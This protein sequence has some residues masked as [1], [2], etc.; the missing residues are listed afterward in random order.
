MAYE[1]V[2]VKICGITNAEDALRAGS[3]GADLAGFIFIKNT[4][5]YIGDKKDIILN[6]PE[7]L[8]KTMLKVGLFQDE[9]AKK[10]AESVIYCG[11]DYVQLQG[12]ESPEYCAFLKNILQ[13]AKYPCLIKIIKAF[14]I[15][16][17]IFSVSGIYDVLSYRD[18]VDYF[19]FDTFHPVLAGGTGV[20]FNADILIKEKESIK[21]PF[22]IAGGLTPDNAAE[23]IKRFNP[24]GVDV[25]SG[26][27]KILG[28]KDE[29]LLKEFI[30]N[31]KNA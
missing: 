15:K 17:R 27:E 9:D 29:S 10:V 25:S 18:I 28:K 19:V 23:I 14:K 31:A 16:D 4:P 30:A 1:K 24:Y 20:T 13:Q 11:L 21:K 12:G 8:K 6:L 22:F 7:S 3:Y 2:K 26:V 5:R